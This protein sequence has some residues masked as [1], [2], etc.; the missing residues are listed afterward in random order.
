MYVPEAAQLSSAKLSISS[1]S[2]CIDYWNL[3]FVSS[4][5]LLAVPSSSTVVNSFNDQE[6]HPSITQENKFVNNRF[7]QIGESEVDGDFGAAIQAISKAPLPVPTTTRYRQTQFTLAN[8]G[9]NSQAKQTDVLR[10][11]TTTTTTT[12]RSAST[13]TTNFPA[14]HKRLKIKKI[15][16]SE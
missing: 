3:S 2:F 11:S 16:T 13:T 14:N 8:R 12:S 1:S 10:D 15:A 7:N 6:Q 9:I 5:H 4:S